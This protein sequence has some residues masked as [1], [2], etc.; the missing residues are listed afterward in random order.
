MVIRLVAPRE[1]AEVKRRERQTAAAEA[2]TERQRQRREQGVVEDDV[3]GF[4]ERQADRQAKR[5]GQ[6]HEHGDGGDELELTFWEDVEP[7]LA[8]PAHA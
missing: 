2:A 3:L 4:M 7:D 5:Q 1:E 8:N 6:R